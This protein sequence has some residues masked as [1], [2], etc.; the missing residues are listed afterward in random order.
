MIKLEII[1]IRQDP[2]QFERSRTGNFRVNKELND[3]WIDIKNEGTE[4]INLRGR[5]L[6][7]FNSKGN[8]N[9]LGFLFPQKTLIMS[10]QDVPLY[11]GETIRMFTGEQPYESTFIPD[12]DRISRVIWLVKQTYLWVTNADEAR[13]YVDMNALRNQQPPLATYC[14]N[15]WY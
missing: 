3:E 1:N 10:N 2:Q 6:A 12:E 14:Y 4:G 13:L 7:A 15:P 5:V 9:D 11:P 8:K